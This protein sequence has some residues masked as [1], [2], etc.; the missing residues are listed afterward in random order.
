VSDWTAP[1]PAL[2]PS[3]N[4]RLGI[5]PEAHT[6]PP[7]LTFPDGIGSPST[8]RIIR[9]SGSTIPSHYGGGDR[10]LS[11]HGRKARQLG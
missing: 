5:I 6:C 10:S 7:R 3:C 9:S 11:R 2:C 8:S 4:K 1:P